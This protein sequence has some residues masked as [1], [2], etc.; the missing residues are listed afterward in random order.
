MKNSEPK[1]VFFESVSEML[2][3]QGVEEKDF[4]TR[5]E[6]MA[7]LTAYIEQSK[8]TQKEVAQILK[9]DQPR[10]SDLVR[11]KLSKF[12]LGT[13]VEYLWRLNFDVA[14]KFTAPDIKKVEPHSAKKDEARNSVKTPR[15]PTAK[16]KQ[17]E[18][19]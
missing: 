5:C 16:A 12:S 8:M 15:K 4:N 3:K 18:C 2:G 6:L 17:L 14:I 7:A 19:A 9:V 11:G 13:L 10:V 1:I